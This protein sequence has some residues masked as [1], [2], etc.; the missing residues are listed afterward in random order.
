MILVMWRGFTGGGTGIVGIPPPAIHLAGLITVE[1]TSRLHYYYLALALVLIVL[2][3]MS[4]LEHSRFG[5]TLT[6]VRESDIL[7]ESV[8]IDTIKYKVIAFAVGCACAAVAGSFFAH[9]Y[10]IVSPYKFTLHQTLYMYLYL[11]FGG[12]GSLAGPVVGATT[13]TLL[14]ESL[15]IASQ[16]QPAVF[17]I[18]LIVTVWLLPE[19]LIGLRK[20]VPF[21]KTRSLHGV[22]V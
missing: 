11:I 7:S 12:A 15:R 20:Y 19:G 1:F 3:V 4:R 17:G 13:L 22:E 8:A 6:A 9:Y 16:Y 18:I 5:L 2:V 10:F 21:L 14:P